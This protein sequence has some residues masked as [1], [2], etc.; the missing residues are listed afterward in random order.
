MIEVV[1]RIYQVKDLSSN[2]ESEYENFGESLSKQNSIE[3][4]MDCMICDNRDQFKS[5]IR[6]T[7]GET[8]PFRFSRSL[9]PGSIYC[10]IIGEH[11]YN[12]EKYFN[13]IEYLCDFC[14]AH[15][16]TYGNAHITLGPYEIK[17]QLCNINIELYSKKRFC[18]NKCKHR[19]I[20]FEASKL[21]IHDDTHFY[22]TKD[23]FTRNISGYIYKITKKSTGEFYVG[24]TQY[25]PIF[26]WGEHLKTSRFPIENIPDYLFEVLEI[27]PSSENILDREKYYIQLNYNANPSKCLNIAGISKNPT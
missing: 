13:R 1:Y 23:M 6:S 27:V 4:T 26:R 2:T 8:I 10:I 12:T 3:L 16:T 18:S 24:Q 14:G 19:F 11:C 20:E 5:I 7:Y 15:V 21:Q 22:V 9:P 25:A 17:N